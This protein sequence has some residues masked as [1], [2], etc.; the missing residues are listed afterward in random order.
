MNAVPMQ[1]LRWLCVWLLLLGGNAGASERSEQRVVYADAP[2][3]V[4]L[5]IDHEHRLVFPEPVTIELPRPLAAATRSL[6]ADEQVVYMTGRKTLSAQR[7]IA[8]ASSGERVYLVDIRIVE[9]GP[10]TDYRLEAP[11]LER[12]APEQ[13]ATGGSRPE[14]S[15]HMDRPDNPPPVELL[16]HA[17]QTLYAPARLRPMHTQIRRAITPEYPTGVT[18]IHSLRGEHYDYRVIGAWRGF[19]RYLTAVEIINRSGI[20]VELDPRQVQ[21]QFDAVAFQHTWLGRAG[22]SVDRTTLY[23][24]S[25]NPFDVSVQGVG[26]GR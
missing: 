2:V 12:K 4:T 20:T 5:T 10:L 14:R 22:T 23:V 18:L 1:Q 3:T 9:D 13:K 6:Q 15:S 19:G 25:D 21:G 16:R 7:L 26:Y 17:S 11:A 8:T 24:I